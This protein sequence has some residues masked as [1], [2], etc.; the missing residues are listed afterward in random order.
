[1]RFGTTCFV[2]DDDDEDNNENDEDEDE[3][4][5]TLGGVS[6]PFKCRFGGCRERGEQDESVVKTFAR[7]GRFCWP[8][9]ILLRVGVCNRRFPKP[10]TLN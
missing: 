3:D 4:G 5:A 6:P 1:M 9:L 8:D 2:G 7:R 10:L